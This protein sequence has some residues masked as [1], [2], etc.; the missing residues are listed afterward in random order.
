MALDYLSQPFLELRVA[1]YRALSALLTRD[2]MAAAVAACPELLAF[3]LNPQSESGRQGCEWRHA[4][5]LVLA[6]TVRAAA[7]GG[8]GAAAGQYQAVLAAIAQRVDDVAAQG[9]YGAN[10]AAPADFQ[11]ATVP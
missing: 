2:W 5:V 7:A 4:C 8:A 10:R 1:T 3:L 6:G 11:V 9:P